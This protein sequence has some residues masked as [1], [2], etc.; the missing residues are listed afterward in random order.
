MMQRLRNKRGEG[1]TL[2]FMLVTGLMIAFSQL[3]FVK[4]DFRA[5]KA[6][7]LCQQ[8]YRGISCEQVDGMD[9][10]E[11]LAYIKDDIPADVRSNGGNFIG[12][13]MNGS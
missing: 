4:N 12:G 1:F 11:I 3:P 5:K 7:K 9:K 8:G 10:A 13:N 6:Q 2:G